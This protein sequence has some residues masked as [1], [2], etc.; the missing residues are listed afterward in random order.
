MAEG[1][2][3]LIKKAQYK[4]LKNY[5]AEELHKNFPDKNISFFNTSKKIAD[6]TPYERDQ[7]VKNKNTLENPP[8]KKIIRHRGL[9]ISPEVAILEFLDN[10]F[11][12]YLKNTENDIIDHILE[13]ELIFYSTEDELVVVMSGSQGNCP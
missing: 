3:D 9:V 10:I 4:Y 2:E 1:W 5:S 11:D 7:A 12:N 6:I 8:D 13:I